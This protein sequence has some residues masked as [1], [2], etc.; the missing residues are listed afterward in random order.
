MTY[1]LIGNGVA[2]IGA[3]EG[4]R[5]HDTHSRIIAIGIEKSAPYGRPLISYL[6]A[7]KISADQLALRPSEFYEKQNVELRLGTCV[8]SIDPKEKKVCTDHGESIAYDKLLI[9]T[10]GKPFAPPI[11]RS[12]WQ[13]YL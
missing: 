10:G 12:R 1:V 3:I 7:G 5:K 9:A 11:P 6:L 13:R 2:T 4:I 8:T